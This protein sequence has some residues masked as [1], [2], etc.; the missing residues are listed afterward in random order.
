MGEMLGAAETRSLFVESLRE[1]EAVARACGVELAADAVDKALAMAEGFEAT[2]T[3]S[4]QR[5]VADGKPFEL[6]AFSG[7]VVRMGQAAGVATP[8]HRHFYA[9]LKPALIKAGRA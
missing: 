2:A 1:V 6:E 9:L 5:D 8:V 3:T 4:M 7:T